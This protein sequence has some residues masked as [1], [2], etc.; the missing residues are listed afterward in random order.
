MKKMEQNVLVFFKK[1]Y[2]PIGLHVDG[3]FQL[4]RYNLQT[5]SPTFKSIKEKL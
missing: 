5:N 4:K 2:N 1:A 3:G